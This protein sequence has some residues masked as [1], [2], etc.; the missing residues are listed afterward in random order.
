VYVAT[1]MK[2]L[3]NFNALVAWELFHRTWVKRPQAWARRMPWKK[4]IGWFLATEKM[5]VYFGAAFQWK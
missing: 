5:L 4:R 1:L 2:S 3:S